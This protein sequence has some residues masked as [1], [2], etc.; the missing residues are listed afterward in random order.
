MI[1]CLYPDCKF[2][3]VELVTEAEPRTKGLTPPAP[4]QEAA[5]RQVIDHINHEHDDAHVIIACAH[6]LTHL[7]DFEAITRSGQTG[8]EIRIPQAR[9]QCVRC[10]QFE[11]RDQEPTILGEAM[12]DIVA[13]ARESFADAGPEIDTE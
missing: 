2:S 7:E 5:K 4:S 11:V 8:E 9:Y 1:S 10:G 12:P 13:A 6:D 3:A